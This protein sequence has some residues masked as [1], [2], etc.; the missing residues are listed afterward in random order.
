MV[1]QPLKNANCIVQI[2]QIFASQTTFRCVSTLVGVHQPARDK[3][4][5]EWWRRRAATSTRR[6]REWEQPGAEVGIPQPE[7]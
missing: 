4:S 6:P 2:S 7:K 1:Y 3:Q 5:T